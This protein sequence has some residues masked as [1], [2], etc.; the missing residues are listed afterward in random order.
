MNKILLG[1]TKSNFNPL[2]NEKIW[3]TRHS[4][5]CD[6]Y[7]G[8]GYIGNKNLHT[9]FKNV[10]LGHSMCTPNLI[11]ESTRI[12]ENTWWILR[13]LFIQAYGL[14]SCAEIYHY[15]GHQ[16]TEKGT[17]DIIVSREKEK[18]INADLE[19]ILDK[20]WEVLENVQSK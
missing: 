18:I 20:I 15:G 10:F 4:W 12:N 3:L 16:T 17:T 11:F 14:K 6:W 19:K 8:F 13:D 2:P 9:H 7:W 1:I 5:D